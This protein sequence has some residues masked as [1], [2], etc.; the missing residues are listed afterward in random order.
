IPQAQSPA[1][2]PEPKPETPPPSDTTSQPA[3]QNS[4][5]SPQADQ[6]NASPGQDT[7]SNPLAQTFTGLVDKEGDGYVLKVQGATAYQLD[8]QDKAKGF[9]GQQVRVTGTLA[10]DSNLIHVQKI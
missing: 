4:Q 9:V 6:D 10:R 2:T 5:N 1:A 8:D 3:N 7:A